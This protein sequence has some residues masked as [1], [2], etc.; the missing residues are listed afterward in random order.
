M[1]QVCNQRMQTPD[2]TAENMWI[3]ESEEKQKSF[4]RGPVGGSATAWFGEISQ[5]FKV[6]RALKPK[7][8]CK[9]ISVAPAAFGN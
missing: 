9:R 3:W 4:V 2:V 6:V 7:F 5:L 8:Q 1:A